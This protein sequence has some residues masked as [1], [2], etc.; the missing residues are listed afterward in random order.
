MIPAPRQLEPPT[1]ETLVELLRWRPEHGVISVYIRLD[2]GDRRDAWR[3]ELRHGLSEAAEA[4]SSSGDH[5]AM[6]ALRET[7]ARIERDLEEARRDEPRGLIGFV[8]VSRAGGGERW[9]GTQL[10]PRRTHVAH[11]PLPHV[12][13]LLELLDDGAGRGIAAVSAERVRLLHWFLGRSEQLHD[14]ELEYFG[15]DWRERKAPRPR[16]P[17]RGEAVSASGRDQY[18]QR[19]EANRERFAEQTGELAQAEAKQRGWRETLVFGDERYA[20]QFASGFGEGSRLRH[21]DEADLISQSLA[22]IER[23]VEAILPDLNRERET[24]LIERIKDAAY[25][26]GR[27][28]LGVQE[29][30]QALGEGRVEHLVYDAGRDYSEARFESGE[31]TPNGLP[32][33]DRMVDLALATSAAITPVEGESAE[34][35]EDQ[36]GVAALLRY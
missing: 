34:A 19:L 29:T 21:V 14:W 10:A 15:E 11:E 26:G 24:S 17:A 9:Y 18:D 23:R 7:A 20:Q 8:E 2:P 25:S 36:G 1:A 13:P 28:S 31:P 30:L 16:D 4:A 33:I 6:M 12:H 22:Q 3:T 35:L 32:L 5:D 27:S